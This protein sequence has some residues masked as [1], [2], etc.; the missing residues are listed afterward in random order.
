MN[1]SSGRDR[2]AQ[3]DYNAPARRGRAKDSRRPGEAM[4]N[5]ETDTSVA[6][7]C[8]TAAM[9]CFGVVPIFL[10]YLTGEVDPAVYVDPWTVNAIRYSIAALL[11][12]PFVLVLGRK[13]AARPGQPAAGSVW[14]AALVPAGVNLIGQVGWGVSP[15]FVEAPTIGFVIR[16]SFLFTVL[17]GF[18]MIPDERRLAGKSTFLAGAAVCLGGVAIMFLEGLLGAAQSPLVGLT[19][20][21]ATA[22]FWGAYAVSVR[23]CM[24]GYPSRVAFGVVSLYTA[25]AL[26]V[27]AT[28]MRAFVPGR[29]PDLTEIC[30]GAWAV[31]IV[32]GFIGIAFGHI[33]YYRGIHRLGA[34]VSSGIML[35]TPF[36]TLATAYAVLGETMTGAQL[37]GGLAV[38][39]GG[40]LLLKA[41]A[42]TEAGT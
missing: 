29:Y 11:W 2:G 39:A 12:L 33:L 1:L 36:V 41:K 13:R 21:V 27:L 34:V 10:R 3:K 19:I 15:Y 23:L 28:V 30:G 24:G 17:F 42:Q 16:T 14:R 5:G 20:V 31:M 40:V 9:C 7:L 38:V 8:V 18:L 4:R 35:G 25:G 6:V 26:V 32:S 37:A 22:M